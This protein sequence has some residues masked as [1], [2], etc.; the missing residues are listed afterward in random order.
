[1]VLR[2]G[3]ARPLIPRRYKGVRR[4]PALAG[5]EACA[6]SKEREAPASQRGR[7]APYTPPL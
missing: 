5:A 7:K 4:L 2:E 3:A 6:L 1:M